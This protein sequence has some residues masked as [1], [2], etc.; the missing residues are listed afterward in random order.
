MKDIYRIK[1]CITDEIYIVSDHL[2]EVMYEINESIKNIEQEL[3]YYETCKDDYDEQN[4]LV[5]HLYKIKKLNRKAKMEWI[6]FYS[7]M[8]FNKLKK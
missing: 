5:K 8:R 4:P 6:F 7:K 1:D 3:I 2:F